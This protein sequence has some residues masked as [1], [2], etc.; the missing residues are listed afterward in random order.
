MA[1]RLRGL[2]D[3]WSGAYESETS[4]ASATEDSLESASADELFDFIDKE[5]GNL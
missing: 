2:L 3:R 4:E 1:V 5:I